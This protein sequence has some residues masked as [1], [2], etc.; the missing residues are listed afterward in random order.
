MKAFKPVF[1]SF[2]IQISKFIIQNS[3]FLL[4]CLLLNLTSCHRDCVCKTY[5]GGS[6]TYSEEDVD[7]Q[8]VTCA[9]MIFQAG[10]QFYAVCDWE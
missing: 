6:Y 7:D 8:G 1:S 3:Y 2:K 9:N 4:A 5:N 10:Q